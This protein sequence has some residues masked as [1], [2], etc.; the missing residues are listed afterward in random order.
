MQKEELEILVAAVLAAGFTAS[1]QNENDLTRPVRTFQ[2]IL[3]DL[4]KAGAIPSA[5]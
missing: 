4:R 3:R 1:W 5:P 2:S